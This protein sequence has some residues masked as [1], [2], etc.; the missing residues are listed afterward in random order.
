MLH[1][2]SKSEWQ[3][4]VDFTFIRNRMPENTPVRFRRTHTKGF[5]NML[6]PNLDIDD[7]M[8]TRMTSSSSQHPIDDAYYYDKIEEYFVTSGVSLHH[9]LI[10]TQSNCGVC[11]SISKPE[12]SKM[13]TVTVYT[14]LKQ[15]P[16]SGTVM[17]TRC[18]RKTCRHRG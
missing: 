14:S 8:V 13:K 12:A 9:I 6:H 7:D 18:T 4:I 5:L 17:P 3:L 11:G 2:P 1:I 10:A 15:E 16:R